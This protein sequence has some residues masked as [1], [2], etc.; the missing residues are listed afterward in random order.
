MILFSSFLS[1]RRDAE[2]VIAMLRGRIQALHRNHAL[3]GKLTQ[4][5]QILAGF[6]GKCDKLALQPCLCTLAYA[7]LARYLKM[8]KLLAAQGAHRKAERQYWACTKTSLRERQLELEQQV[9][10]CLASRRSLEKQLAD[11]QGQLAECG[12]AVDTL[13]AR[14]EVAELT[15]EVLSVKVASVEKKAARSKAIGERLFHEKKDALAARDDACARLRK[16]QTCSVCF[17]EAPMAL[18]FPCGHAC[19]CVRC[20]PDL[21]TCPIC[22]RA[23]QARAQLF[24]CENWS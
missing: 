14:C 17:E 8:Q 5:R 9:A 1:L 7:A 21:E 11:I 6:G 15:A 20:S 19:A 16:T 12:N 18:F 22:T 23:V 3:N 24:I 10:E 4:V 13:T 2:D